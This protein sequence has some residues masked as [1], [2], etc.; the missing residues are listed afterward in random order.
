M[1]MKLV[2]GL[3]VLE[4]SLCTPQGF[5]LDTVEYQ[6][7]G[8]VSG[9]PILVADNPCIVSFCGEGCEANL[10][11]LRA[12]KGVAQA[13]LMDVPSSVYAEGFLQDV[14]NGLGLYDDDFLLAFVSDGAPATPT[15]YAVRV[16]VCGVACYLGVSQRG[17]SVYVTTD[18]AITYA[19]LNLVLQYLSVDYTLCVM[20]SG[21]AG[22]MAI[23]KENY[24][25]NVFKEAL[26]SVVE[27]LSIEDS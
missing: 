19:M 22:N 1:D 13:V 20:A 16:D 25:F 17:G 12:T 2:E 9:V 7:D 18:V 27:R 8:T 24:T 15:E 26:R 14:A 23:T 6:S 4:G 3:S 11:R 10:E 5:V 21:Q